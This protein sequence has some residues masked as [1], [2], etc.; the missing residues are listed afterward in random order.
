MEWHWMKYDVVCLQ[1]SSFNCYQ[2]VAMESRLD[3]TAMQCRWLWN[4]YHQSG[5]KMSK[6]VIWSHGN[7]NQL[8]R[9]GRLLKTWHKVNE[10]FQ[11]SE[12]QR[13]W[14]SHPGR[15]VRICELQLEEEYVKV[16]SNLQHCNTKDYNTNKYFYSGSSFLSR[17][18]LTRWRSKP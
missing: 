17:P 5:L 9:T 1:K 12:T 15:L 4:R 3:N 7:A 18:H 6:E 2:S 10:M 14:L 13:S 8:Q 16:S 11:F